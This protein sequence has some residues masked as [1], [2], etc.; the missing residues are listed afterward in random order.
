MITVIAS[1]LA[2]WGLLFASA[3][4]SR[5]V[6]RWRRLQAAAAVVGTYAALAAI[7]LAHFGWTA[8]GLTA[9]SG[10]VL[11][12]VFSIVLACLLPDAPEKLQAEGRQ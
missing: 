10:M 11:P 12:A 7:A 8:N 4:V 3:Y 9:A 6:L 1:V 5:S 2:I